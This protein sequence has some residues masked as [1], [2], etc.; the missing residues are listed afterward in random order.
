MIRYAPNDGRIAAQPGKKEYLFK[1]KHETTIMD[2]P[3]ED[4]M[5]FILWL[6]CS[7]LLLLLK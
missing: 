4:L 5:L 1:H 2:N 6:D 7:T 3:I